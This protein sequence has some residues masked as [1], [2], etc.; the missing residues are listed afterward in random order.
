VVSVVEDDVDVVVSVVVDVVV[1]VVVSV[2][3]VVSVVL[4]LRNKKNCYEKKN[5][6]YMSIAGKIDVIS[7]SLKWK[8][9]FNQE[10]VVKSELNLQQ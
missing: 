7:G 5:D 2:V 9:V 10:F 4:N 8:K 6:S 3:D 1:D